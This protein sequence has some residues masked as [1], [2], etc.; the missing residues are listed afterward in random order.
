MIALHFGIPLRN[1]GGSRLTTYLS[2]HWNSTS[3][4]IPPMTDNKD[5]GNTDSFREKS[6]RDRAHVRQQI[7]EVRQRIEDLSNSSKDNK[8]D[9][10]A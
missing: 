7:D 10:V 3:H 5:P 6:H 4:S 1:E 9:T 8:A 2:E